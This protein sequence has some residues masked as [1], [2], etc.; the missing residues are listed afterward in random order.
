MDCM[1]AVGNEIFWTLMVRAVDIYMSL[2]A[3]DIC[4]SATAT[5]PLISKAVVEWH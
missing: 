2:L 4:T 5:N 3:K 1:A